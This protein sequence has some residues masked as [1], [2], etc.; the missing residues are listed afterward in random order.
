MYAA[1]SSFRVLSS[2]FLASSGNRFMDYYQLERYRRVSLL[3]TVHNMLDCRT[4]R[5][6]DYQAFGKP[7]LSMWP[8]PIT[9]VTIKTP[10]VGT[11]A[12]SH[13]IK[14][15]FLEETQSPACLSF[16]LRSKSSLRRSFLS[17]TIS[18]DYCKMNLS[19]AF[20]RFSF[21]CRQQL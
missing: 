1:I 20:A 12:G 6:H 9:H 15:T 8:C 4:L 2:G 17:M 16:M 19:L 5:S 7:W 10:L 14:S 21:R 11:A 3:C 13:L 18:A